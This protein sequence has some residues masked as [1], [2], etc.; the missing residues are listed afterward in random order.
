L[1]DLR[2]GV[3]AVAEN[4]PWTG[5]VSTMRVLVPLVSGCISTA[6]GPGEFLPAGLELCR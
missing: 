6:H 4:D 1:L 3:V 5:G 2:E